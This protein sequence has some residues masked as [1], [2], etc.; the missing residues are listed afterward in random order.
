MDSNVVIRTLTVE[1]AMGCDGVIASLPYHFGNATGIAEAARAVRTN[2]GLVV[3]REDEIAG[4]LTIQ[5]HFETAAEIIWMA[6]HADSRGGGIGT[7]LIDHLVAMLRAEGRKLLFVTTLAASSDEGDVVDS[8]AR[9]RA[10]YRKQGFIPMWELTDL[11][12]ND[13]ALV[14]VMPL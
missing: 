10:F 9:T 1:D 12:P 2:D 11:W 3:E 13:P 7:A 6:V 5:R 4:F 8:Y 14:L